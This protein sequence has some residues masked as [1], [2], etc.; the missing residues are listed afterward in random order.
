MPAKIRSPFAPLKR[1][2]FLKLGAASLAAWLGLRAT[3][4]QTVMGLDDD[5]AEIEGR[6]IAGYIDLRLAPDLNSPATKRY[7]RDTILPISQVTI[8]AAEPAHNRVWYKIGLEGYAH[9][10]E[11]QPVRTLLNAVPTELPSGG[12]LAEV[13]VPYTDAHL[14]PGKEYAVQYRYYYETTHWVD[15]ILHDKAGKPWYRV[16][17][18]KWDYSYYVPAEHLR[19]IPAEELAP[20]SPLVPA[21]AKRLEVLIDLQAVVAYEWDRP[22]FMTKAATGADFRN[23]RFSTPGGRHY[24]FHKRPSRHMAAGDLASNGYDLPGVPWV[25]YIT[26]SGVAFHGTYWHNDFGRPRSHGC[27]NLPSKASKWLYRW[28]LPSVPPE[29]QRV[30]E[31]IGT[32]V[33]VI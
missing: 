23:G 29:L 9:S 31:E 8:G 10:G 15:R 28:T 20:L 17:D 14:S 12:A 24:T 25:S 33:D 32:T 19:L 6:V 11:V 5:F 26:E 3:P 22:V 27:I 21:S 7:W 2:E 30:Y 18:D 13:S 1:R 16:R 4:E